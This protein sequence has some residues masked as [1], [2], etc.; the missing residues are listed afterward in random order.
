MRHQVPPVFQRV[1]S[2]TALSCLYTKAI[3]GKNDPRQAVP[4]QPGI[5]NEQIRLMLAQHVF[6]EAQETIN[7][8][9]CCIVSQNAEVEESPMQVQIQC[10]AELPDLENIIDGACDTIYV[11]TNVLMACGVPD[12]PHM[13]AVCDANDAKFP[14]GVAITDATGKYRKP[15]GW[16]PPEHKRALATGGHGICLSIVANRLVNNAIALQTFVSN[17]LPEVPDLEK[18]I[19]PVP[20]IVSGSKSNAPKG[21]DHGGD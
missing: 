3:A 1:L 10:G 14:G 7:A 15:E 19:L 4:S 12:I 13:Q 17:A 8:L 18:P 11:S 16:K 21:W 9:G 20:P 5:P 2:P 6:E